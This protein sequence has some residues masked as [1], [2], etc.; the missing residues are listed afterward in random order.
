M[1]ADRRKKATHIYYIYINIYNVTNL[2]IYIYD[3][4]TMYFDLLLRLKKISYDD[5]GIKP[6]R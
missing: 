5:P 6:D 2:Y 4:M 3:L 1:S